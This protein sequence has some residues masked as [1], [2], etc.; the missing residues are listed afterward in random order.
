M[1]SRPAIAAA[2]RTAVRSRFQTDLR[3]A[4]VLTGGL[5]AAALL[6]IGSVAYAADEGPAN[7]QSASSQQ[8]TTL[9]EITVTGSRIKRT[10]DFDSPNPTTV[11]DS[12]YLNNLGIVNVGQAIANLP[13][14]ISNNT[15]TTTGNANFFTGS[16][17]A[18]LRGLNP[19]FGS[20]TLTLVN[21]RRFVPTNQG[22]GVD[23]NFIPSVMIDR[24]DVVTGGA[25]AAYGSGAISGVQN[26]FLNN[27]LEG[28]R[29]DADYQE[30]GHSDAKDKHVA[31]AFGHGFANG[32]GHFVIGGEYE[33]LDPVGCQTARDFCAQDSGY[34]GNLA[35]GAGTSSANP[36]NLVGSNLRTNQTSQTGVL[37]N[38]TPGATTAFQ[39][40]AA[41]TGVATFN[42]GQNGALGNSF[43]TVV[44]GDGPPIYLHTNLRSPVDRKV[45]TATFNFALTDTV[46]MDIDGSWGHVVST[47]QTGAL[48]SAFV[49]VTPGNPFAAPVLAA[50]GTGF[51]LVN[52]GWDTQSSSF[53]TF[54][55]KVKR[56]SIGFDGKFGTS[57]WTWDA[58]YQVGRT[59]RSQLVNDNLHN[60]AATLAL[61]V[62]TGPTG[63]PICA[64]NAP[65]A[66]LPVGIDP[67]LAA[68]CVPINI[69][70][71]TA[72][73]T[74][75]HNYL[76]GNL[77]EVLDYTQQVWA[78]NASGTLFPGFGAGPVQG[79]VGYEHRDELGHNLENGAGVGPDIPTY[80]RTDYLIQYGEP[81]SGDVKVDE[82]YGEISLPLL[83]DAP[84]AKKLDLDLAARESRYHNQGLQ[85]TQAFDGTLF[86]T[87][88][89]NLFTWKAGATYD[90]ND[91]LRF[92][93]SQSRDARAPNF[94]ELYY[95]QKIGAGGL[96]GFCDP[97][98][99]GS[100][101]DPCNWSLEGNTA[102]SPETSDTTTVGFVLSPKGAWSGF[103]FAIDYFKINIK[104]AI[105]QAQIQGVYGG[106]QLQ[107][108][109]S[110][111]ALI[112]FGPGTYHEQVGGA[113]V[114]NPA[115]GQPYIFR[116]IVNVRAQSFNGAHYTFKGLDFTG[117][118]VADLGPGSLTL[119]LLA[120]H[121][122]DQIFQ[123]GPGAA[124]INIVGQVGSSNSFLSDNQPTAK[125]TGSLTGTYAQGPWS[126]TSQMRFVS[127]GIIDYNAPDGIVQPA[128]TPP[129]YRY[130]VTTVPSYEIFSLGGNYNFTNLGPVSNLQLFLQVDNLFDKK[131]PFASG[132]G[133]FGI[134]N[135]NGGT[136]T[137]FYDALGRMFRAGF[138]MN[139]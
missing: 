90:V 40:N 36:V 136:N 38:N 81:F 12:N 91:W 123:S 117:S 125:W 39:S 29:L 86:P 114:I 5:A 66:V 79:A 121:M 16:T 22:D 42:L 15:P 138:R 8:P 89:H 132:A 48:A 129:V 100:Q 67:A 96:F 19:F 2:V 53:T 124:P 111:C 108:I 139:F 10:T 24:V 4:K 27:K 101:S 35:A 71:T 45:V 77:D 64:V 113:D 126:V 26:I 11:V 55:T 57:S 21:N 37:L 105:E 75:Q 68:A 88:T 87:A 134:S 115:N 104:A 31:A 59:D 23:L 49:A 97:L 122:M 6:G 103:Q 74:A 61:N 130:N 107:N 28:G 131:P 106:C 137:I 119:R 99:R 78:A 93:G 63:Q 54:D 43:N 17:I 33:K 110:D 80:V 102:L 20:R 52:K 62:V 70:G 60:N 46:N 127:S 13:S 51:A 32:R 18:N 3:T 56:G 50:A 109:A 44:G 98:G 58:Y 112:Q 84:G 73:T 94:R 92:R 47:N 120:E 7:N 69:F 25:S 72:L 118:W 133:A 128:A 30:S 85:G 95:G 41:G 34:Y 135:A 1:I 82:V 76:F 14:N 9:E 116:D 65:G 83:K